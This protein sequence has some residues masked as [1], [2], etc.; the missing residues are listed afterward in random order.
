MRIGTLRR[1]PRQRECEVSPICGAS[2][3]R[4][5][6]P[7]PR[8]P[9]GGRCHSRRSAFLSAASLLSTGQR[10]SASCN[11]D[12]N[13]FNRESSIIQE[14]QNWCFLNIYICMYFLNHYFVVV[15]YELQLAILPIFMLQSGGIQH[16]DKWC[17]HHH[18]PSPE[19][20]PRQTLVTCRSPCLSAGQQG[21]LPLSQVCSGWENLHRN[22]A[23]N[24]GPTELEMVMFTCL[25]N[26]H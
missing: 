4:T 20:Y 16:I 9:L 14:G 10:R 21:G 24:E 15:K 23:S 7:S 22:S 2:S 12:A 17:H 6:G 26:N 19:L 5:E 25:A 18:H 11:C 1:T 3:A 13:K 8:R